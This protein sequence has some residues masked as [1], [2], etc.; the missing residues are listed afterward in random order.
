MRTGKC[1]D[2]IMIQFGSGG[3]SCTF[4]LMTE[5]HSQVC[6]CV[7]TSTTTSLNAWNNLSKEVIGSSSPGCFW[8]YPITIQV[9]EFRLNWK[10][11]KI[12]MKWPISFMKWRGRQHIPRLPTGEEAFGPRKTIRKICSYS[13]D[14]LSKQLKFHTCRAHLLAL[15]I[16]TSSSMMLF[17]LARGSFQQRWNCGYEVVAWCCRSI[18]F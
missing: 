14:V 8:D 10:G 7:Q 15:A 3:I 2:F 6:V 5:I 17:L 13:W 9:L 1:G 12:T 4:L 11:G 18:R 16:S